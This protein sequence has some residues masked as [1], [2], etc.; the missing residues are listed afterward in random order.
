MYKFLLL[1]FLLLGIVFPLHADEKTSWQNNLSIIFHQQQTRVEPQLALTVQIS[2][3]KLDTNDATQEIFHTVSCQA[4][5]LHKNWLLA[6]GTCW[7]ALTAPNEAASLQ[8]GNISWPVYKNIFPQPVAL[9]HLILIR[10]PH[11]ETTKL[12]SIRL[13]QSQK[14]TL[15]AFKD[16]VKFQ[17]GKLFLDTTPIKKSTLAV[18]NYQLTLPSVPTNSGQAL[19]LARDKNLYW[20]AVQQPQSTQNF[21]AFSPDDLQFI[22]TTL[23]REDPQAYQRVS[24]ITW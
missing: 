15:L 19:I 13:A 14:V 12:L 10:V 1:L 6:A 3:R 8:M 2:L 23:K 16:L 24:L 9:P 18:K 5:V 22:S 20:F 7:E 21:T 11:I 17:R 4:Y